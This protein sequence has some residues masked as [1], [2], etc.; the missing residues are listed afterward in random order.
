MRV[1][2]SS[3]SSATSSRGSITGRAV[4]TIAF[5]AA[6][7]LPSAATLR[8][9]DRSDIDVVPGSRTMSP[10]EKALAPDAAIGA[11]HGVIILDEQVLDE[12]SGTD[13]LEKRH[14]RAKIHS[15]EARSLADIE[16]PMGPGTASLKKWWA[17][18]IL[19][20]GTVRELDRAALQ[21]QEVVRG[22]GYTMTA[23]KAVIPGVV[24]GSVVDVGWH[25]WNPWLTGFQRIELQREWPVRELRFSWIPSPFGRQPSYHVSRP[26]DQMVEVTSDRH[27]ILVVGHNLSAAVEEPW[28]PP[29]QNSF[30]AMTVYYRDSRTDAKDFWK[31]E[32]QR[33]ERQ[34]G[35]HCRDRGLAG[36]IASMNL[37]A[38][39]D[40][41]ARL[42][43]A[44]QWIETHLASKVLMSAED[45]EA[46]ADDDKPAR[47]A[48]WVQG[49]L[50]GQ[51]VS[52]WNLQVLF[53]CVARGLGAEA[54]LAMGVDRR[55]RLF[56]TSL[57]TSR[58]FGLPLGVVR[59]A[60]APIASATI[61]DN[62]LGLPYGDVAWWFTGTNAFLADPR[63][64]GPVK[65]RV[66]DAKANLSETAVRMAFEPASGDAKVS[67]TRTGH[68]Q[69]GLEERL[70]LRRADPAKRQEWLDDA[71][72][73][74]A[75]FEVGRAA[76]PGLDEPASP[77]H[78]ECEG[79]M[80]ATNIA[81]DL[82]SYSFHIVGPW[83]ERLPDLPPDKRTQPLLFEFARTETATFDIPV[84]PGFE[85]GTDENSIV[86]IPS[87]FGD[88][89]LTITLGENAYRVERRLT[90]TAIGIPP[91]EYDDLR[92]FLAAVGRADRT[93][94]VFRHAA[95][96]NP[97]EGP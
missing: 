53:V 50:A 26:R 73:N 30:A 29:R 47:A 27:G 44:Y 64:P 4:A 12:S 91:Q 61:V 67:W 36:L 96:A 76:A 93:R 65:V 24:P 45:A 39:G 63:A 31:L 70:Q 16:I 52:D 46:A 51:Q 43:A 97:V 21:R 18:A 54:N 84:P 94:L 87:S 57:L 35:E 6:A 17:M 90:V 28:M 7:Y 66:S 3:V 89:R 68:G 1:R 2:A 38:G 77:F 15:A 33:I 22:G 60:G 95:E 80:P 83:L 58:Q 82:A 32:A 78:M 23:L 92:E 14:L 88:Y 41:D 49:L 9:A 8:A 85:P 13:T 11:E 10:E 62:G 40:L 37:P 72:G 86:A 5:L 75:Y 74:S 56:D 42:R 48:P 55:Q 25:L 69:H 79:R 20:D 34:V 81:P 71:C 19:P 59:P